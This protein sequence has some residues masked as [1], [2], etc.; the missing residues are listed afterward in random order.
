MSTFAKVL[1]EVQ[2]LRDSDGDILGSIENLK[3]GK[4]GHTKLGRHP[5]DQL[6]LSHMK[7]QQIGIRLEL[8]RPESQLLPDCPTGARREAHFSAVTL[9]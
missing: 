1:I 7:Y 4:A 6:E 3:D 8:R 5:I 2:H 9:F